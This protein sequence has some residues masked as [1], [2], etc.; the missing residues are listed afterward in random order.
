MLV[1]TQSGQALPMIRFSLDLFLPSTLL[2][3]LNEC[4]ELAKLLHNIAASAFIL[5]GPS[6][7]LNWHQPL[8]WAHTIDN[9]LQTQ[10]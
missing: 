1:F 4:R 5:C 7:T 8:P 10:E 3:V 6:G 2:A 9:S